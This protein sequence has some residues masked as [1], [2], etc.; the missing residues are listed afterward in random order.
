MSLLLS[1][2]IILNVKNEDV[3]LDA[4]SS[5]LAVHI[6]NIDEKTLVDDLL[7]HVQWSFVSFEKLLAFFRA[8]PKPLCTN[9]H[10]KALFH[11]QIRQRSTGTLCKYI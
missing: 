4:L 6:E 1:D 10:T 7:K 3:V 9:I 2:K 11:N 8:F 5:W